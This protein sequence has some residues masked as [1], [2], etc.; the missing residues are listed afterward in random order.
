MK[1]TEPKQGLKFSIEGKT[2]FL[3]L[4]GNMTIKQLIQ[5]LNTRKEPKNGN[6]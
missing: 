5:I 4:P 2:M 3:Q 1:K 6:N